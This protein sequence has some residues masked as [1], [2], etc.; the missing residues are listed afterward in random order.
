MRRLT[1][2]GAVAGVLLAA[3]C[4]HHA[5]KHCPTDSCMLQAPIPSAGSRIPPA[6]VPTRPREFAPPPT[7]PEQRGYAPAPVAPAVPPRELVLPQELK[8][9]TPPSGGLLG[10]PSPGL[11]APSNT[12]R[13]LSVPVEPAGLPGYT[14]VPGRTGVAAGRKPTPAGFDTLK[15]LGFRTVVYVHA[16]GTD[17]TAAR[18]LASARGLAFAP[19]A[20][21]PE[22]LGTDLAAFTKYVSDP[23]GRPVYIADDSGVRAGSL[24]YLLFRTAEFRSD[25]VA[26]VRAAPLGLPAE[27]AGEEAKQ[28]WLA[29]QRHLA[30]P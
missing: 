14:P 25:E 27:T 17:V 11:P 28:F 22:T 29:I 6:D 3:G 10:T 2:A 23:A 8:A 7:I 30:R 24:W 21:A 1:I 9:V 19:L 16:P 20:V 12:A 26:R 18:E 13:K 5:R 4:R 15:R